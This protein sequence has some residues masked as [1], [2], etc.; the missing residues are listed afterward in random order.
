MI[1]AAGRFKTNCLKLMDEVAES[2]QEITIT[3]RGRPVAKLVPIGRVKARGGFGSLKG[4]VEIAGDIV[5]P[6]DEEWDAIQPKR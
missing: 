3:K 5:A 4:T 2:H 6:L 1:I